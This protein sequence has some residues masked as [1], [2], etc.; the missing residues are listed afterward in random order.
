MHSMSKEFYK[1]LA[2]KTIDY[3]S[4]ALISSGE[5][6]IL[7]LDNEKDVKAYYDDMSELLNGEYKDIYS[8]YIA[9]DEEEYRTLG[10]STKCSTNIFVVP[11][12][13]ITNAYMTRLRNTVQN[14]WAMLIVCHSPIDSIAGGTESLQKEGMP[15]HR[16]ALIADIKDSIK[17]SELSIGIKEL[18]KFDLDGKRNSGYLDSYSISDHA[19]IIRVLENQ[20]IS[21]SEFRDFL[22]FKDDDVFAPFPI[23][24]D[25]KGAKNRIEDNNKLFKKAYYHNSY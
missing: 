2:H 23:I 11:E 9:N 1:Y 10:F 12:L 7:R 22:L 16:D 19:E 15:F 5:K 4:F 6:F 18:L 25:E 3:F 20:T 13:E 17:D 24:S 8:E 14:N 21:D